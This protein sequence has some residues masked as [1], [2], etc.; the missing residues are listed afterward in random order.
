M[1]FA[2]EHPSARRRKVRQAAF[3][4]LDCVFACGILA[5]ALGAIFTVTSVALQRLRLGKDQMTASQVLQQRGEKLRTANWQ[6]VTDPVWLRDNILHVEA[7][8]AFPLSNRR[9]TVTV[10]PLDSPT[11]GSNTFTRFNYL[12]S[13]DGGNKTFLTEESVTIRW[14]LE[15]NGVPRNRL[16]RREIVVILGKGGV[17]K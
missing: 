13:A 15:W 8:G 5:F 12:A 2:P 16:H 10:T 4:L 17:A 7:D 9:E 1:R 14:A 11:P 6:R 3:T